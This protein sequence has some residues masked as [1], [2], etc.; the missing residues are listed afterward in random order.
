MMSE[1]TSSVVEEKEIITVQRKHE[2]RSHPDYELLKAIS[3][4]TMFLIID[5]LGEDTYTQSGDYLWIGDYITLINEDN[6]IQ[7][8]K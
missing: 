4:D 2:Y 5:G 3:T 1:V 7:R 6:F 8:L